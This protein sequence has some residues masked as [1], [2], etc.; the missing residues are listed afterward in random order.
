MAIIKEDNGLI[1]GGGGMDIVYNQK[2]TLAYNTLADTNIPSTGKHYVYAT[3]E[4]NSTQTFLIEV[5]NGTVT[6]IY[7]YQN[8]GQ[9]VV[10]AS[11]STIKVKQVYTNTNKDVKVIIIG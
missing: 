7:Y 10:D 9:V 2:L 4:Q 6:E 5:D 3:I 11:G 1:S 8:T